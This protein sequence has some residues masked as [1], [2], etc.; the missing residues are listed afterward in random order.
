MIKSNSLFVRVI[1]ILLLV[2]LIAGAGVMAYQA[3]RARGIVQAPEMAEALESAIESGQAQ[4]FA[5]QRFGRD[6]ATGFRMHPRSGFFPG[7]G[8]FGL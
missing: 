7:G 1:S 2:G 3:G 4:P 6:Y 5:T 8:I